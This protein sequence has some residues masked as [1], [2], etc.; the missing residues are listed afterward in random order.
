MWSLLLMGLAGL[1]IGGA[2]S[3]RSQGMS[4]IIVVLF[5]ILAG[6]SLLGAYLLI[7]SG[8]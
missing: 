1:L 7:D 4:K 5:W 2:I 6:M 8:S 3:F